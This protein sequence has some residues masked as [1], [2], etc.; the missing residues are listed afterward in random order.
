VPHRLFNSTGTRLS[1]S[2]T[3]TRII[4]TVT[5]SSVAVNAQPNNVI[6][7]VGSNAVF[8]VAANGT[9]PA[10]QWQISTDGGI[11]YTN[12][13][14]AT[15]TT[16]TL[17]AVTVAMNN[18]RYRAIVSNACPSNA[19]SS[20]AILTTSLPASINAQPV[21]QSACVGGNV[22]FSVAA[23]GSNV[24]YQW[25]VSTDGG[26]S[27]TNI[28]GATTATY[29]LN[30]VTSAQNGNL[31]RVVLTGCNPT[32]INSDAVLLTVSNQASIAVQ[33]SNTPTCTGGS[34]TFNVSA[35]GSS[36]LYQWQVSTDGGVTYSNVGIATASSSL[37]SNSSSN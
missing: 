19:T 1:Y 15:G 20:E 18:N 16:L 12:I 17:T 9:S 37:A 24:A 29:S 33:P 21:A 26:V 35:S 36:L 2:D 6:A 4:Q 14:G 28:T 23:A 7:C 5:C 27:Y 3:I 11:T 13:S 8:T 30:S 10:Y 32:N 31:Y 34:A 22:I 25:Q